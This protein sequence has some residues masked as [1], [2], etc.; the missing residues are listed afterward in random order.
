MNYMKQLFK[1]PFS[2]CC[3]N[4]DVGSLTNLTAVSVQPF[5]LDSD[6]VTV[7]QSSMVGHSLNACLTQ[8]CSYCITL[9][10]VKLNRGLTSYV[11]YWYTQKIWQIIMMNK[12]L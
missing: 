12:Y 1:F 6:S 4:S 9:L 10:S 8:V 2:L 3:L 11:Y 5:L 7:P